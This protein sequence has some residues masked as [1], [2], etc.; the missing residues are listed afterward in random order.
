LAAEGSAGPIRRLGVLG[1]GTMGAGIAQVAASAGIEVLLHDPLPGA[2]ERARERVAGFLA[3]RVEKAQLAPADRDAIMA[4]IRPQDAVSEIAAA[5]LVVEAIPEDLDLKRQ[6][7]RLLDKA[8]LPETLLATNTSSLSVARIASAAAR[9]ERVLGM[10][11]FN[12]VPLM[13]LVEVIPGPMTDAAAVRRVET[14]VRQLGKEA[15]VA[16]DT[17]GFIVNRVARPFYLEAMRIVGEGAGE[18]AGVDAAMRGIGFRMGPFELVDAIGLDVNFA[19]SQSVYEQSFFEPRYR[20]HPMQRALVDAGRL[21]RKTGGGFYDY[22]ADGGRGAVWAGVE[23]RP[24]GPRVDHLGAEQIAA[25]VLATIVNEAA[26]AVADAVATPAAIDTAMRLGTNY[27]SGPLEWGERIGL[28]HV[29]HT[30]DAL[31]AAV[32]DGRYRAVP[33][34]RQLADRGGSFFGAA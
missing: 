22:G 26:S 19:V 23:H 8:A 5:E 11:F 15:V 10:H 18:V 7:F 4:R 34:L 27:P 29:L 9:P 17:P 33:L 30:L 12:P 20:P 1:A 21:G 31:N 25:R 3:R 28:D 6:A 2:V 13:A 24:A 32:P 16:A 14:V